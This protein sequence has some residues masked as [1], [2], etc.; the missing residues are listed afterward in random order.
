MFV[1][2]DDVRMSRAQRSKTQ[3]A[4]GAK[5]QLDLFSV[6]RDVDATRQKLV[7]PRSV[8]HES[9]EVISPTAAS[10]FDRF[11]KPAAAAP[12]K[13]LDQVVTRSPQNAHPPMPRLSVASPAQPSGAQR[14]PDFSGDLMAPRQ[15]A[16]LDVRQAAAWLGL[17][18]STLDKMR[19]YGIGPQFIR[20]TGR[21]VR[22]D[23]ADLAA[24]AAARRQS[25]TSDEAPA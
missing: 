6:S 13:M 14:L 23:P 5:S 9:R 17:S 15:G 20:A 3:T 10:K 2:K 22:Y 21:A 8:A 7:A 1:R 18:K 16:L 4:A 11:A 12:V 19:C 25:R 24:F